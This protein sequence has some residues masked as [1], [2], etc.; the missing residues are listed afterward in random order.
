MKLTLRITICLVGLI[1]ANVSFG[2]GNRLKY[3]NK[4][5]DNMAYYYAYMAYEDVLERGIDSATV[6]TNIADSY[7]KTN[8]IVKANEWYDY[9]SRNNK[10]TQEEVLEHARLKM[11]LGDYAQSEAI[12]SSYQTKYGNDKESN[13]LLQACKNYSELQLDKG[14]FVLNKTKGNTTASEIG[15]AYLNNDQVIVTS[16]KKSSIAVN[17]IQAWTGDYYYNLYLSN[18]DDAGN[19]LKLKPLKKEANSKYHDGPACFD[20]LNG[21]VY[22][23]RNSYLKGKKSTDSKGVMRLKVYR[24]SLSKNGLKKVE[25]LAFNSDEYSCGHPSISKDGKTLYFASDKPGGFGG[26]DIYKVSLN[27][28]GVLGQPVNLGEKINTINDEFFPFVHPT[29]KL[30]FFSSGGHQGLGGQ[31]IFVAKVGSKG[32]VKS[33]ENVG[34]PIN[35]S[36][37]EFAFINNSQQTDGYISSN[38]NGGIGKHDIYNFKQLIPFNSSA[39]V[40]GVTKDLISSLKLDNVTVEL[41]DKNG[42]V[43]EKKTSTSDGDFDFSLESITDD[44]QLVVSK[45]GYVVSEN[46]I[47]FDP[48]TERYDK[49]LFLM[50]IIDYYLAGN[51]QDK[52]TRE[53]LEGVKISITDIIK[54]KSLADQVTNEVGRFDS[55]IIGSKYGDTVR[56]E[57]VL[58]KPGYISKTYVIRDFLLRSPEVYVSG[59]ID[60]LLTPIEKGVDV[61]VEVGLN[62]IYFDVNSSV[63]RGESKIELDKIISFLKENPK[64]SIELGAHTDCR[65][66]DKYN[67][68]LSNRRAKNSADYIKARISNSKRVTY[69]GYGESVPVNNCHCKNG[70]DDCSDEEHQLNRRTEFI[71]VDAKK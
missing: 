11:S 63:L 50:P 19:L 64:V 24:G 29:Q 47:K 42:K 20:S 18:T 15:I 25:E 34:T 16:S 68:W 8:N 69:K 53:Q 26:A 31:D 65:A 22:F 39:T 1:I 28:N 36:Q 5:Y 70:I 12:V 3:A 6:A 45:D 4:Q 51:V 2:Q 7:K 46:T 71:I 67:L 57:V 14:R 17:R 44:F 41:V 37:D 54:K 43:V 35:T 33:I 58:S 62:S 49:D 21:F 52:V 38:R 48:D 40:E 66:E 55:E 23:T 30:I 60:V 13:E 61:G 10:L 32:D 9:L 56:Y 59:E 27:E